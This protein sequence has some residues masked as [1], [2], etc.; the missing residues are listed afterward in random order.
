MLGLRVYLPVG[1][2]R[3]H[4]DLALDGAFFASTVI[5]STRAPPAR[6]DPGGVDGARSVRIQPQLPTCGIHWHSE[7]H[8]HR[9]VVT[10]RGRRGRLLVLLQRDRAVYPDVGRVRDEL[11][12]ER[13]RERAGWR[14]NGCDLN[15]AAVETPAAACFERD[16][17]DNDRSV[18]GDQCDLAVILA[19]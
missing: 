16:L 4:H 17:Q 11:G 13:K 1:C 8:S 5:I 9:V 18:C 12:V 7:A 3:W 2:E 6:G 19:R 15:G 10:G 14:C